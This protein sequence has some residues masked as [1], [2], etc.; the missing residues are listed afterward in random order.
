[1]S[2]RR[3]TTGWQR[4][5]GQTVVVVKSLA[6]QKTSRDDELPPIGFGIIIIPRDMARDD[7][8]NGGLVTTVKINTPNHQYCESILCIV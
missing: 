6:N 7:A 1:M 5:A 2:E 3:R 8:D 4:Y